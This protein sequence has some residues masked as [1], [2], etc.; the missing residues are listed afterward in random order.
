MPPLIG[1]DEGEAPRAMDFDVSW[2]GPEDSSL[3]LVQGQPTSFALLQT[4]SSRTVGLF[5]THRRP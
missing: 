2:I 4:R 1:F 3:R 5:S